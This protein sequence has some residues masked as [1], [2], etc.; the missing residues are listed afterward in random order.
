VTSP[1]G[2]LH[3]R[4]AMT[5]AALLLG[6]SATVAA[7][8]GEP[9]TAGALV[10][11]AVLADTFD[12]RFAR[13]FATPDHAA[14]IGPELDSLADA[15]SFGMAPVACTLALGGEPAWL[16]CWAAGCF[17]L[18]SALTRL[19]FFNATRRAVRGFIG[20]PAPAAALV[21][22]STL[23][24]TAST[25]ALAAVLVACGVA[26]LAPW[27]IPR[28]EGRLLLVFLLWPTLVV[29]AHLAKR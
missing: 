12:G 22:A 27:P 19:A 9:S 23:W 8:L 18:V 11:V 28:P 1:A 16:L 20:L 13:W 17:Y 4:N 10:G 26:M 21:W 14:A 5:Y 29:L 24:A 6:W 3:A 25:S 2:A 7:L 15:C